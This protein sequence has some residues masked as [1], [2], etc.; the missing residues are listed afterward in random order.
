MLLISIIM[1]YNGVYLAG[2]NVTVVDAER[3][4]IVGLVPE[5]RDGVN[6]TVLWISH[7]RAVASATSDGFSIAFLRY[8]GAFLGNDRHVCTF[9]SLFTLFNWMVLRF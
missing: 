9:V 5:K 8:E 6:T 1:V 7:T 2:I 3:V 4:P